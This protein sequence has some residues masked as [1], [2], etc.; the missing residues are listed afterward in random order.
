MKHALYEFQTDKMLVPAKVWL[1]E[2]VLDA[3][4]QGELDTDQKQ[5]TLDQIENMAS[6]PIAHHHVAVTPDCHLGYGVPVGGVVATKDFIIPGAVGLDIGCGMIAAKTNLS[7]EQFLTRREQVM[8]AIYE[9]I[10]VGF[11][12]QGSPQDTSM[13]DFESIEDERWAR[14]IHQHTGKPYIQ[15][16]PLQLGTLGG[17][18]HFI[19]IQVD[20]DG[21]VWVMLHSGSRNIGKAIAEEYCETAQLHCDKMNL[22]LADPDLSYLYVRSPN[23]EGYV[24]SMNFALNF[25]QQSRMNMMERVLDVMNKQFRKFHADEGGIINAHHNYARLE[26]HY[27]EDVW[28]HRKGAIP[29][30]ADELGIIPGSMDTGSYIVRGLGNEASFCTASH[31]SG[32]RMSRGQAIKRLDFEDV[33]KN[34]IE[35]DILI[36]KGGIG[37]LV[38]NWDNPKGIPDKKFAKIL[39]DAVSE[40][41][42]AY[43][44][45]E[46]VI[47]YEQDLVTPIVKLRPLA[48]LKG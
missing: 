28:V 10:P 27:G 34:L 17:G 47:K 8:T 9:T 41:G 46:D 30:F 14:Q 26:N 31:G 48:C 11:S 4:V 20:E 12:W 2:E 21:I 16:V 40:S 3:I 13:L 29:A 19:E 32:R 1:P 42:G 36:F 7:L 18:N 5:T 6:L 38:K 44:G 45:I 22:H 24:K 25:A 23:G 43:K 39:R 15:T 33:R 35:R 37:N